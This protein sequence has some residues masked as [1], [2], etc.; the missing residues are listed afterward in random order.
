MCFAAA[1]L[2]DPRSAVH[3]APQLL[4]PVRCD[5]HNDVVGE[6]F[7]YLL[8]VVIKLAAARAGRPRGRTARRS[9]RSRSPPRRPSSQLIRSNRVWHDA[10]AAQPLRPALHDAPRRL[11]LCQTSRRANAECERPHRP[12]KP[13]GM[14]SGPRPTIVMAADAGGRS[15]IWTGWSNPGGVR[16]VRVFWTGRRDL[17]PDWWWASCAP[18][19]SEAATTARRRSSSGGVADPLGARVVGVSPG[20][21]AV[22]VTSGAGCLG[23]DCDGVMMVATTAATGLVRWHGV[24]RRSVRLR[25]CGSLPIDAGRAPALPMA[26]GRDTQAVGSR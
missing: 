11:A 15:R 24:R 3:L 1:D 25:R 18:P 13:I 12:R 22:G 6:R 2:Q 26:E 16:D 9:P 4:G 10:P 7:R 21:L 20:W 17:V 5:L 14:R 23:R 8:P 19:S